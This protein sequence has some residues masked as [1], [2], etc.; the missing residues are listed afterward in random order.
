MVPGTFTENEIVS[1]GGCYIMVTCSCG[2]EMKLH[3]AD[4]DEPIEMDIDEES[5]SFYYCECGKVRP[6][7][8]PCNERGGL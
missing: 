8:R 4:S 3:E 7:L 6:L 2:K 1:M 5:G